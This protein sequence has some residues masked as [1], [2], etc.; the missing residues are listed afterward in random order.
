V[1]ETQLLLK[2]LENLQLMLLVL[3]LRGC[4]MIYI[5]YSSFPLHLSIS[6]Q[7]R[8]TKIGLGLVQSRGLVRV[9]FGSAKQQI[10]LLYS[11]S[12]RKSN[13]PK[14]VFPFLYLKKIRISKIYVR[15]G[16]FQKYTPVA[17]P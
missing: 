15:F 1:L 3:F 9:G 8:R 16:K 12:K 4:L 10:K 14:A 6:A 7:S 2:M 13:Y 17:L 5:C 11:I